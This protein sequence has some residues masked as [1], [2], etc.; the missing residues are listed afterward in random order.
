MVPTILIY[1]KTKYMLIKPNTSVNSSQTFIFPIDNNMI[2]LYYHAF[3][4]GG[5]LYIHTE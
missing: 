5:R 3:H 2:Q 4:I 1:N